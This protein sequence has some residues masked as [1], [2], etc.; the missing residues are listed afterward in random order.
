MSLLDTVPAG[1][2]PLTRPRPTTLSTATAT[3]L[4]TPLDD[5][6]S[7]LTAAIGVLGYSSGLHSL[8]ATPRRELTV[9]V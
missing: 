2:T 1:T 9:A 6:R 4:A 3:P 8:L 5:A 7:Q